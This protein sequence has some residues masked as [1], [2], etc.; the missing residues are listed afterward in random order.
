MK[1][2]IWLASYPKSGNTWL[3]AF[4]AN[5]LTGAREPLPLNMLSDFAPGE[6]SVYWFHQ[7]LGPDFPV[8]DDKKVARLRCE[9]QKRIAMQSPQPVFLKT[10]S[11][12][13]QAHGHE[14]L[15][16]DLTISAIYVVRNPLDVAISTAPHFN[17]TIDGA[18]D[19]ICN[20]QSFL[21]ATDKVVFEQS[22][23]WSTHVMS[24]TRQAHPGL[25]V[26]RYEDMLHKPE[27]TFTR[28]A[29]FIANRPSKKQIAQAVRN[30]S[31]KSLQTLEK[32]ESFI[33]GS[34][35]AKAFFR[36]G[37]DGQWKDNLT[38]DQIRRIVDTHREQMQRFNY[39]PKGY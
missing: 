20:E 17:K 19:M 30:A 29:R 26:V 34:Q 13:G 7:F 11:Y 10:H 24:W 33:E 15:N 38:D 39:V 23:D 6:A 22:T 1:G 18:I 4:I 25:L 32:R 12:L 37:R 31:F 5:L 36:K 27:K 16:M 14:M 35:F 2:I 28:I 9:V 21:A 8:R 3:R